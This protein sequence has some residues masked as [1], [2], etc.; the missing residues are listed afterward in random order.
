MDAKTFNGAPGEC[1]HDDRRFDAPSAGG[2]G[3]RCE[4]C[5][6][7]GARRFLPR[8]DGGHTG[9]CPACYDETFAAE[10]DAAW[11]QFNARQRR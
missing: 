9:L 6:A 5:G 2:L 8:S 11:A 3:V 4:R 10:V 7:R 1:L